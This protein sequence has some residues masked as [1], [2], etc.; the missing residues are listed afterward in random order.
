[1]IFRSFLENLIFLNFSVIGLLRSL[2]AVPANDDN[3]PKVA[4]E[5]RRTLQ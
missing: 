2:E 3:W 4:A 1:M 5:S